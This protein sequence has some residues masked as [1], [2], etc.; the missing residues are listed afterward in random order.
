MCSGF[1]LQG[2]SMISYSLNQLRSMKK[3]ITVTT[4]LLLA[5]AACN[6]KDEALAPLDAA[7]KSC[8]SFKPGSYWIYRD[9][10]S[11]RRDSFFI[12]VCSGG[13]LESQ[14]HTDEQL[15]LHIKRYDTQATDSLYWTVLL[16]DGHFVTWRYCNRVSGTD[17]HY[18]FISS[19]T[20]A[21]I[22]QFVVNG[23]CYNSVA[24]FYLAT[25]NASADSSRLFVKDSVGLVKISFNAGTL[26]YVWEL[27][28]YHINY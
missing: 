17:V 13:K 27:E 23:V 14:T 6:K 15:V 11:G 26:H 25:G 19:D 4:L 7:L 16:H 8:F 5:F 12:S 1:T 28:R 9:S 2:R 22:P 21:V 3:Y 10:L 24:S 18:P 20:V